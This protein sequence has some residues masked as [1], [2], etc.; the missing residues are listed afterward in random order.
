MDETEAV[1]E[2][3]EAIERMLA[4]RRVRLRQT[5]AKFLL[6][7]DTDSA[8][9]DSVLARIHDLCAKEL[10]ERVRITADELKRA[11]AGTAR[12]LAESDLL[13]GIK[14]E[15]EN[16]LTGEMADLVEDERMAAALLSRL[17]RFLD[18]RTWTS[19]LRSLGPPSG[20]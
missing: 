8:K 5:L 11:Y 3:R 4:P 15:I 6:E 12:G 18:G 10:A 1:R 13:A 9:A 7:T 17:P 14:S 19:L 20:S 2:A 16:A